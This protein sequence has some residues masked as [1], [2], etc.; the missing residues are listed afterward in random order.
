LP[1]A[2]ELVLYLDQLKREYA[3]DASDLKDAVIREIQGGAA[4][5]VP[6]IRVWL[7]ELFTRGI[8]SVG[9]Q[10]LSKIRHSETL[11]NRQLYFIRGLN[12][13]VNF[14]RRQKAKFDEKNNFEKFAFIFG[15]TCLPKDE[16]TTWVAAIKPNM[17]RPLERLLCDWIK[18]KSGQLSDI[19]EARS[20]LVKD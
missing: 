19:M 12:N 7:M 16:F 13:D 14:F 4:S 17:N 2:K 5:S 20:H 9:P 6:T 8:L 10:E 18:N 11:D 3:V 15:A 1:F